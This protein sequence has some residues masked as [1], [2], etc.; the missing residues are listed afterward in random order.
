MKKDNSPLLYLIVFIL[1]T[2]LSSTHLQASPITIFDIT[3]QEPIEGVYV[4]NNTFNAVSDIQGKVLL[5]TNISYKE[6]YFQHLQY[7]TAV[8]H[9]DSI[10]NNNNEVYLTPTDKK[11]DIVT[12]TANRWSENA[13]KVPNKIAV[14]TA[15]ENELANPQT[16][17]DLLVS[18]GEVFIQKSQLGGGSPM[19]RGFAANRLLIVVDGVRMN[20]AIYRSGNLQNVISLDPASIQSTEILFGPGSVIYGSDALGGVMSFHT[21]SPKLSESDKMLKHAKTL[22]RYSTSSNEK[23]VHANVNIAH[24]K[25]GFLTSISYSDFGDVMMGKNGEHKESSNNYTRPEYISHINGKDRTIINENI[26][27]QISTGYKQMNFVEK[28]KYK[29]NN[30]LDI[31]YSLLYSQTSNVPRYDRLIQYKND[32]LK[33]AEWYYGPQK[34]LMN[35]VSAHYKKNKKVFDEAKASFAIQHYG[36]SRHDRK[37]NS[38]VLRERFEKVTIYSFNIDLHKKLKKNA[39]LY[40]GTEAI[41]NKVN[42]HGYST[43]ITTGYN[44]KIASR[45]PNNSLLST[46]STYSL[47]KKEISNTTTLSAG[48]RFSHINVNAQFNSDF[49]NFPFSGI[50]ITNKAFNGT[51]GLVHST[52]NEWKVSFNIASGYRAPNID[53]IGKIFDSEPGAVIVPNKDLSPEYSYNAEM[54]INGKATSFLKLDCSAFF[55]YLEDAITRNDFT[56]NGADS[57]MYDGEM[58]KVQAMVN[59]DRA[60]IWGASAGVLIRFHSTVS[61]TSKINYITGQDQEGKPLR[62]VTPLFGTTKLSYKT[63]KTQINLYSHYNGKINTENLA[64]SE[65]SKTYLYALDNQGRPY[66]PSWWTINIKASHMFSKNIRANLGIENILDNCYRPYSSGIVSSGRNIIMSITASIGD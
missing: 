23:T 13:D 20:N 43:N 37:L 34:W 63:P 53:D 7:K 60:Y 44:E 55:T 8:F 9:I 29:P 19:I 14:I 22:T 17:A 24:K 28:L 40:Y 10:R 32:E 46:I 25:I 16:S 51:A 30:N 15:K 66:S 48:A 31:N 62:H 49:Y 42:S 11:L 6:I 50:H 57:I 21:I 61:L 36:E 58:S 5:E 45:Y 33:Y 35:T 47:L 12:V 65:Q 4:Y 54:G 18:S 27:K 2:L 3:T 38:T 39:N 59:Q 26:Y 52:T 56:F 41:H 64:P 1:A